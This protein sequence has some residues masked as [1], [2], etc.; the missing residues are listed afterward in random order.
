MFKIIRSKEA[1]HI[2]WLQDPRQLNV[3]NLSSIKHEA[4][5]HFWNKKMENVKDK[6]NELAMNIKN[7]NIETG[8]EE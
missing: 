5:R 6:I 7:K 4:S 8:I 3:D 2:E 1:S